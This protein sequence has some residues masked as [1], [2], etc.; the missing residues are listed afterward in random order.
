MF[1]LKKRNE[2]EE[3]RGKE[4]RERNAGKRDE[5][6]VKLNNEIEID[7]LF[8]HFLSFFS[9]LFLFLVLFDS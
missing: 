5:F 2:R 3:R 8:C 9:F 1:G 4:I 7:A 6:Y